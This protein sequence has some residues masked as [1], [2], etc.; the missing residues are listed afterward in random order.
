MDWFRAEWFVGFAF[1]KEG[2][3]LIPEVFG[4]DGLDRS[5][6]PFCLR[7]DE[8]FSFAVTVG[9]IGPVETFGCWVLEQLQDTVHG[10]F[11]KWGCSV[12]EVA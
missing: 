7:F 3:A 5:H 9:V 8:E 11:H 2:V 10:V 6:N 1:G 12:G 4:N